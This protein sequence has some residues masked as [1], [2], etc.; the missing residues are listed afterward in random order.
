MANGHGGPRTPSNP[1]PVSGPG[2]LSQRTDGQPVRPVTGLPY[3]ENA[4][5]QDL[6]SSAPMAQAPAPPPMTRGNAGRSA[7]TGTGDAGGIVPLDAPTQR[8]DEPL[9][10]GNPYGPGPGPRA[11]AQDPGVL[12]SALRKML[13]YDQTGDIARLYKIASGR[14][15]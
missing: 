12:S 10:A 1:A 14:G 15:W 9:T 5:F 6:Q 11:Q 2:A 13:A 3:G 8:P 7:P 4:D